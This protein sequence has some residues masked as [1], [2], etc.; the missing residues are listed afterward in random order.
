M[1]EIK[2]RGKCYCMG[3]WLYGSLVS[4][5]YQGQYIISL[6]D[7]YDTEEINFENVEVNPET[8]GQFIGM[9]DKNGKEIYEG[10]IVHCFYGNIGLEFTGTVTYADGEYI[11]LDEDNEY[12][13]P[14][15]YGDKHL[16]IIGN[17][18]DEKSTTPT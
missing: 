18:H 1:R 3:T 17:I 6:K 11:I 4:T 15:F 12:V 10:D 5:V 2:F 14:Q 7:I 13:L 9:Y 8:V 16:E